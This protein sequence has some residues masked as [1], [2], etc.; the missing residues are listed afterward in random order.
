LIRRAVGTWITII[1]LGATP[2]LLQGTS[3]ATAS[4]E[5]AVVGTLSPLVVNPPVT[6]EGSFQIGLRVPTSIACSATTPCGGNLP[7]RIFVDGQPLAAGTLHIQPGE[8]LLHLVEGIQLLDLTPGPRTLRAEVDTPSGTFQTTGEVSVLPQADTDGDKIPDALESFLCGPRY[9][10]N[11]DLPGY[12]RCETGN[13]QPPPFPS[14]YH[15]FMDAW[16]GPD[17]DGDGLISV[18]DVFLSRLLLNPA[19]SEATLLPIPTTQ[20]NFDL[21]EDDEP[22]PRGFLGSPGSGACTL[23][24]PVGAF[25]AGDADADGDGFPSAAAVALSGV[26]A[27]VDNPGVVEFGW[28]P[29]HYTLWVDPDDGDATLPTANEVSTAPVPVAI[30]F[31][32]D[33]DRDGIVAEMRVDSVTFTY[34]RRSSAPPTEHVATASRILDP[35]EADPESPIPYLAVDLDSDRIP[36][37]AEAYLCLH[38]DQGTVRDGYCWAGADYVAPTSY[39]SGFRDPI[40]WSDSLWAL[41]W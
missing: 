4:Q 19:A 29:Y 37:T 26:C 30:G 23:L 36:D 21:Y 28:S 18:A 10:W 32:P 12:A 22:Q 27:Y 17:G 25:V 15:L 39:R 38:E 13:L 14:T 8:S 2:L 31:G 34:S 35:D 40:I 6:L 41:V 24:T 3:Q 16:A 11:F 20:V 33:A 5:G 1:L 9:S 7:W